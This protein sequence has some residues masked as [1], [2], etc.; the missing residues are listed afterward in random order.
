MV[1]GMGCGGGGGKG[2]KPKV[3]KKILPGTEVVGSVKNFSDKSG[4]GFI[5]LDGQQL[6]VYFQNYDL[7]ETLKQQY[8]S[9]G[10]SEA[11]GI[12]TGAIVHCWLQ[13]VPNG[14]LRARD[15]SLQPSSQP[16]DAETVKSAIAVAEKEGAKDAAKEAASMGMGFGGNGEL[17][18]TVKKYAPSTEGKTGYGFINVQGDPTDLYFQVKDIREE[19]KQKVDEGFDL[20]GSEVWFWLEM[21]RSGKWRARDV[22]LS[23][24]SGIKRSG[25]F[26]DDSGNPAKRAKVGVAVEGR[27]SGTVKSF[28][29]SFGFLSSTGV[30]E[31]V[32][33]LKSELPAGS[34][35]ASPGQAVEFEVI[36]QDSGK[37]RAKG[38][39]FSSIASSSAAS[40][41]ASAA[42]QASAP[43]VEPA[44]AAAAAEAPAGAAA[45]PAAT[46]AAATAE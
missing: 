45:E 28:N 20:M 18:G 7:V 31:D 25:D 16:S 2:Y 39:T 6:D 44:T 8:E 27:I 19:D 30:P 38:I 10:G 43:A 35:S 36:V 11:A 37:Y 9:S 46:E 22:G 14:R 13:Q 1:M 40:T 32:F 26:G 4:Y 5:G 34:Q 23:P 33:F 29:G 12:V 24:S 41:A 21:E 42:P 3:E 17:C 15:V